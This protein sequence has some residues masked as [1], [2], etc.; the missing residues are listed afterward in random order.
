MVGK[1]G[2][3]MAFIF[4]ADGLDNDGLVICLSLR[5]LI[6]YGKYFLAFPLNSLGK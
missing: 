1:G 4:C 3:D 6:K 2:E 5:M